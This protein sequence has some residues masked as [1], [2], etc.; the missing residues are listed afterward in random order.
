MNFREFVEQAMRE[1]FLKV[2]DDLHFV[3]VDTAAGSFIRMW[4]DNEPGQAW[5]I[6]TS[7]GFIQVDN[8][9]RDRLE[10]KY[11]TLLQQERGSTVSAATYKEQA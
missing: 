9:H 3:S 4:A 6:V 10:A 8:D 2:A 11:Q 1:E 5:F 7:D